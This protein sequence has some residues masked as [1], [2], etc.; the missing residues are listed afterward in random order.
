M[1]RVVWAVATP[2]LLPV[3]VPLA[4]LDRVHPLHLPAP[5]DG[6]RS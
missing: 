2:L 5:F 6:P 1:S 3:L 4:V